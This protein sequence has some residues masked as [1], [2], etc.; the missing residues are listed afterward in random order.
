M[1]YLH[2]LL[3]SVVIASCTAVAQSD[4]LRIEAGQ[5]SPA[6]FKPRRSPMGALLRSVVVPGWGQYYNRKY[7][8]SAIV[9]GAETFFI[10]RA[11]HW[12]VK[13]EDE[14]AS[15]QGLPESEQRA[16]FARY[17]AYRS[18]RNDYLW[19][20]GLTVFF[21]MFDAYVDAHLAGFDVDLT[22]Q[23]SPPA[24]EVRLDLT[25]RF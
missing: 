7:I 12:W 19:L 21:S 1:R 6:D 5:T 20:T 13:A 9:C 14:Y 8:K 18:N 3:L 11:V 4:S 24:D 15:I 23:F 16:A 22:P 10:V 17:S 2:L 25:L